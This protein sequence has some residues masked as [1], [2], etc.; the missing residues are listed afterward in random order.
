MACERRVGAIPGTKCRFNWPGRGLGRIWA[1]L[2]F[3]NVLCFIIF[4]FVYLCV[5]LFV[6]FSRVVLIP[7]IIALARDAFRWWNIRH[8]HIQHFARTPPLCDLKH[9]PTAMSSSRSQNSSTQSENRKAKL[10]TFLGKHVRSSFH[11]RAGNSLLIRNLSCT[12][13]SSLVW[14]R[15]LHALGGMSLFF[16]ISW[17]HCQ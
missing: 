17:R 13:S 12:G 8:G 16:L 7:V 2:P 10:D 6:Y 1:W 5:C 11:I 15:L 9:F 4:W 3:S 14:T